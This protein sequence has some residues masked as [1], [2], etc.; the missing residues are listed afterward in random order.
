MDRELWLTTPT[1][2]PT[3]LSRGFHLTIKPCLAPRDWLRSSSDALRRTNYHSWVQGQ[4]TTVDALHEGGRLTPAR[5]L[6]TT[7]L[8]QLVRI[9][10]WRLCLSITELG[11]NPFKNSYDNRYVHRGLWLV[12]SF[13]ATLWVCWLSQMSNS[14][15]KR[16]ENTRIRLA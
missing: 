4:S 3:W 14:Q 11:A 7:H 13:I 9:V 16:C 1:R 8:S 12:G 5:G 15:L 10:V 2:F 6:P